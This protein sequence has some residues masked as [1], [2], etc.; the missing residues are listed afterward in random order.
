VQLRAG[1]STSRLLIQCHPDN[2]KA[3][4]WF[5]VPFGKTEAWYIAGTRTI[6]GEAAHAYCGFK[7]GVSREKWRE[8]FRLQDIR[9]MLDCLY[10]FEVQSGDCFLVKPGTPHAI[11]S[12]CLFIELHQPCDI[13]LRTERNFSG[14]EAS[15]PQPL[16]DEQ[17]HYGAGFDVLFDCFDYTGKSRE[18]T[19]AE[20]F[21]EPVEEAVLEGGSIYSM[22]G[23]ENTPDFSMKK[24]TLDG[25][26][27]LPPFEGHYLVTTARGEAALEYEGGVLTVPQGRGVFVPASCRNIRATGKAELIL[28]YPFEV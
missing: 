18:Q 6:R 11:G 16:T 26:L 14:G 8:L 21:M 9:S 10:R 17:M 27:V 22:I 1:D 23:Y 7:P 3:R 4:K 28:A 5:N 15:F 24:I 20:V 13:T 12:G 2:E 19:L 25:G